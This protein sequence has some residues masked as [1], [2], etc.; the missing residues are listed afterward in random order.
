M[1]RVDKADFVDRRSGAVDLVVTQ[2]TDSQP[3]ADK[4]GV[5]QHHRTKGQRHGAATQCRHLLV[6]VV[7]SAQAVGPRRGRVEDFLRAGATQPTAA[8][9]VGVAMVVDAG[10][11]ARQFKAN[12][13][14]H[15]APACR[16]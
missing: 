3:V 15:A 1:P 2:I 11:N 9:V 14:R 10:D 5:R 7:R 12:D 6:F 16:K 8:R 4:I 13:T